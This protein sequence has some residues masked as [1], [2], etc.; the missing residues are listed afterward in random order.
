MQSNFPNLRLIIITFSVLFAIVLLLTLLFGLNFESS[1]FWYQ[2]VISVV[3]FISYLLPSCI[4]FRNWFYPRLISD[5]TIWLVLGFA[6]L[7]MGL[8]NLIFDYWYL[9]LKREPNASLGDLFYFTAY[10]SMICSLFLAV[11]FRG[12]DL[13]L[14]QWGIVGF[15][16]FI[17]IG[18]ALATHNPNQQSFVP[19]PHNSEQ[20]IVLDNWQDYTHTYPQVDLISTEKIVNQ[21][22]QGPA[23]AIAIETALE[24]IIDF[25]NTAYVISDVLILTM[26]S[27]LLVNFWGGRFSQTWLFI[28]LGSLTLYIADIWYAFIANSTGSATLAQGF[29]DVLSLL[30]GLLFGLGAAFEYELSLKLRKHN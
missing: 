28:S 26:G 24:P 15:V 4:C 5:R 14:W 17:A 30:G 10:L 19:L 12:I 16:G 1:P 25:L 6:L 18:L 9:G 29:I 20:I 27:I 11:R 8:A 21:Q 3:Q 23:W 22:D 2:V 13:E 7:S